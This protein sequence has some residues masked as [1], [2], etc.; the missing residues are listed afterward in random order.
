MLL[1]LRIIITRHIISAENEKAYTNQ[2]EVILRTLQKKHDKLMASGMEGLF[3]EGYKETTAWEL[4]AQYYAP[5]LNIYPFIVDGAGLIVLHPSLE[6]GSAE[7]AQEGFIRK[8][9]TMKNG[10]LYYTWRDDEKWMLFRTFKPWQWTIGYAIKTEDK[11]ASVHEAA[12][13]IS[14]VMVLS[15]LM[16]LSIVYAMLSRVVRPIKTLASDARIIDDGQYGHQVNLLRSGDEVAQLAASLAGMAAKIRDRDRQIRKFNERLETRVQERTAALETSRR[17]LEKAMEAAEAATVAKREFLANMSH[18]IRTPMNAVISMSGLLAETRLDREQCEFIQA[19]QKSAEALLSIIDDILDFSKIEAG[20]LDFNLLNFDLQDTIGS[21]AEMLSFKAHEKGLEF[22]IYIDPA[23]PRFFIGDPSRLRQVL[24]NLTANAIKFTSQGEVVIRVSADNESDTHAHLYF[25]VT[26]TG[27]GIPEERRNR[28]FKPFS[29]I[30]TSTTR[31]YG[32]T[33]LG[34]AISKKLVDLMDGRIGADSAEGQG[35][36]FWFTAVFEK[37]GR[38]QGH[39]FAL[40]ADLEGERVLVVDDNAIS[41][42]ILS[43]YFKSW[44]CEWATAASATEALEK[45]EVAKQKHTPYDLAIL[46]HLMPGM[47][48][49]K[50]AQAIKANPDFSDTKLILISSLGLGGDAATLKR[51]GCDAYLTKPIKR[52]ALLDCILVVFDPSDAAKHIAPSGD[53]KPPGPLKTLSPVDTRILVAED[54][55][56]NQNGSQA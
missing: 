11:F 31:I 22:G 54:N 56:I 2:L 19:I 13:G 41:R 37:Q 47:G 25:S 28:L 21:V 36:T 49:D 17:E 40:P 38:T 16:G 24:I 15:S 55:S 18:E 7:V 6:P 32:G 33:G 45:I 46:D 10:A 9:L 51:C 43:A 30:D 29:Q 20:K 8:M 42:E 4:G 50:L 35:A 23:V 1:M 53:L 3:A 26:D 44:K 14:I 52:Q 39:K 12:Q 27:V 48:G 34:L 5:G